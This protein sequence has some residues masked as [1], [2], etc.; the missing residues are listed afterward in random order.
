MFTNCGFMKKL[1]VILVLLGVGV[2]F[3]YSRLDEAHQRYVKNLV[4]QIPELPGRYSL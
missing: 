1:F 2:G 4:S 3:W